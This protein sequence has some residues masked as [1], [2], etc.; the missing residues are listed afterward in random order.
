MPNEIHVENYLNFLPFGFC[1]KALKIPFFGLLLKDSMW[2]KPE[3]QLLSGGGT[4]RVH[5]P[6]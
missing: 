1:V 5:M 6:R 3:L 4:N 2:N